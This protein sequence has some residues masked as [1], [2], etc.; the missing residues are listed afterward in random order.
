MKSPEFSGFK[1]RP[2]NHYGPRKVLLT[3]AWSKPAYRSL[4]EGCYHGLTKDKKKSL[5]D[6]ICLLLLLNVKSPFEDYDKVV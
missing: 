6:L 5:E 4:V 1:I 2:A 3:N